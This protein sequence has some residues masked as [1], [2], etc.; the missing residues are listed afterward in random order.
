M[1]LRITHFSP[2]PLYSILSLQIQ[3]LSSELRSELK[4]YH[5]KYTENEADVGNGAFRRNR[6]FQY[7]MT[8]DTVT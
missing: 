5:G 4:V 1:N 2:T 3:I 8:K 7:A 6:H